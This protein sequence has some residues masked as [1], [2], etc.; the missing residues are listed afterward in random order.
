[1]DYDLHRTR[2]MIEALETDSVTKESM[3]KGFRRRLELFG[4]KIYFFKEPFMPISLTGTRC[5][6]KCKHCNSYYLRHML[7]G[8]EGKFHSKALKL[9]DKGARGILLSGGSEPD[10][11]VPA[12]RFA[13]SIKQ[14]KK[15]TEL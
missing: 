12:Y 3:L 2:S 11:S 10:G 15:G 5:S 7:D 13:D 8:S 4:N 6:L 14:L 9:A 1:M